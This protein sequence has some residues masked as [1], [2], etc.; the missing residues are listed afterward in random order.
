M[1]FLQLLQQVS[2]DT[3]AEGDRDVFPASAGGQSSRRPSRLTSRSEL[4]QEAARENPTPCLFQFPETPASSLLKIFITSQSI[5][6]PHIYGSWICL[7][8][9]IQPATYGMQGSASMGKLV[10]AVGGGLQ[11]KV[12]IFLPV[13]PWKDLEHTMLSERSQTHKVA[14]HVVPCT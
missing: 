2:T 12:F 1:S 7:G 13:E 3:T 8:A 10:G 9:V 6:L 5:F 14:W 11:T 4:L